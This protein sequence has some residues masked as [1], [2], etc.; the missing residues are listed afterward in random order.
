MNDARAAGGKRYE[1]GVKEV[2]N[3]RND[4]YQKQVYG[5]LTTKNIAIRLSI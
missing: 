1:G 5:L 2:G 3:S 4:K